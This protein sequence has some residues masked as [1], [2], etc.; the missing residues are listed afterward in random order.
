MARAELA[1]VLATRAEMD[2]EAEARDKELRDAAAR[3]QA[4]EAMLRKAGVL[5]KH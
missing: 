1:S 2:A 5:Q 3:M 4:L